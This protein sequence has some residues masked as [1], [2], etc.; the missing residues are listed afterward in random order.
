MNTKTNVVVMTFLF[1]FL[2]APV[3]A[4]PPDSAPFTWVQTYTGWGP[5][6]YYGEQVTVNYTGTNR[7][8]FKDGRFN[9][10]IE[11]TS[12]I[13]RGDSILGELIEVRPFHNT[14]VWCEPENTWGWPVSWWSCGVEQLRYRWIIP[15]VYSYEVTAKDGF[16]T[17][18]IKVFTSPPTV[19]YNEFDTCP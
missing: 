1:V 8:K 13:Y 2:Y 14:E 12:E 18:E 7:W 17:Y 15:G 19:E 9:L 5:A 16:W 11:G 3:F 4:A 10:M 6:L